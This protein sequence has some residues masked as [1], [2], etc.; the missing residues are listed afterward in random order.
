MWRRL[1]ALA[2]PEGQHI[3]ALQARIGHVADTRAFKVVD[4][5][6]RVGWV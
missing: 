6:A 1:I 5:V 2:E 3:V 4:A